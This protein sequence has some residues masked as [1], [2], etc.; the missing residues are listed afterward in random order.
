MADTCVR[1]EENFDG[2]SFDGY[3]LDGKCNLAMW[4]LVFRRRGDV[5]LQFAVSNI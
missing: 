5:L 2:L 4:V 3:G 1:M